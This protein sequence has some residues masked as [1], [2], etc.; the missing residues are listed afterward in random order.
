M[1]TWSDIMNFDEDEDALV[2]ELYAA[3]M[4]LES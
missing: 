4:E 2:V 1:T 3:T